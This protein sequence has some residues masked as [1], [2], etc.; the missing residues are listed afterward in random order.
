M[1]IF[2]FI[3]L[4]FFLVSCEKN[5]LFNGGETTTNEVVIKQAFSRIETNSIFQVTAVNDTINK[6]LVTCGENLQKAVTIEERDGVVYI[7]HNAKY[8][9]SRRYE[10]IQLEL[11]I[12]QDLI[13]YAYQ[14]LHFTTKGVFKAN[15]FQF[16]DWGKFCEV[17]AAVESDY[18]G[19]FMGA[20]SFGFYKVVGKC[21]YCEIWAGGSSKIFADSLLAVNCFVRQRGWGDVY[22]NVSD[23]LSIKYES[24]SNIYYKNNPT[25]TI[26]SAFIWGKPIKL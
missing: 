22:V 18:C 12:N 20:D 19:I 21:N 8:E 9:W 11:H 1:I 14:P 4:L 2:R 7:S 5:G 23:K 24:N 10:K 6:V 17:D 25:V 15:Y 16:V 13:I 3:I 26:D